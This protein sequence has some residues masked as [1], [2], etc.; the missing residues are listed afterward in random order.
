[1]RVYLEFDGTVVEH[2]YPRVGKVVIGA[3]ETIEKLQKKG[4]EICLNTYR[5]DLDGEEGIQYA[6]KI[7]NTMGL[8]YNVK[9]GGEFTPI[10]NVVNKKITPIPWSESL[11]GKKF[12][13]IDDQA[14]GTPLVHATFEPGFM[15]DWEKVEKDLIIKNIL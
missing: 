1:M 12:L 9:Q 2:A 3:F 7:L 11:N 14:Y 13:F 4:Y 10:E 15:V 6:L 8:R 5:A